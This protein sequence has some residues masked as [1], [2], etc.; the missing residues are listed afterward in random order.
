MNP[1]LDLEIERV[2]RAPRAAVWSAWTDPDR[3]S[4]WFLPKPSVC[5]VERS[6]PAPGGALVTS[7]GEPGG[8]MGPHV[9]GC[10]LAVDELE[11]IVFTTALDSCWRPAAKSGL[12]MTA[13]VTFEDHPDGTHYRAVVSHADESD[14]ARH[15]ELGFAEGWGSVT[16]Q[17]ADLVEA[18]AAAAR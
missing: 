17:L 13:T 16:T 9:N 18:R 4:Q 15:E 10:F 12:R 5:S 6:D 11:R 2:I 8:V 1:D 3:F 14:R 7:M